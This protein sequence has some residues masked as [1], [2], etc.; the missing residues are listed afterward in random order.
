MSWQ[1]TEEKKFVLN[2]GFL[3]NRLNLSVDY[4]IADTENMLLQKE[5][6][7]VVSFI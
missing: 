3:S 1:V 2:F 5:I 6:S 7:G 4:F